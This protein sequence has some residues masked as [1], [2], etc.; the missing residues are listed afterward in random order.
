MYLTLEN[1]NNLNYIISELNRIQDDRQKENFLHEHI[2]DTDLFLEA[3]KKINKSK[4]PTG[5]K[6][7]KRDR[8]EAVIETDLYKE[9]DIYSIL[10]EKNNTEIM[11]EYSLSD[12]KKMY[13]SIYKTNPTSSYTKERIISTLRN[14]MHGMRRAEAFALLAEEREK[15]KANSF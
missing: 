5:Q 3:I 9:E 8:K 15:K 12:L 1:I 14:R 6:K 7:A 13:A 4:I 2:E 11:Q 10:R